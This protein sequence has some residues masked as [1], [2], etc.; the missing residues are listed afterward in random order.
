MTD[1]HK[2]TKEQL[3]RQ[4]WLLYLNQTLLERDLISQR[5]HS[6]LQLQ[7]SQLKPLDS[8]R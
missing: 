8:Y 4:L 2:N 5:Q 3:S 7:I 6:Q 1:P